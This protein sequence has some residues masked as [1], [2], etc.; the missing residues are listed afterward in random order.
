MGPPTGVIEQRI[1][2]PGPVGMP[3]HIGLEFPG[4]RDHAVQFL[5]HRGDGGFHLCEPGKFGPFVKF[6]LRHAGIIEERGLLVENLPATHQQVDRLAYGYRSVRA[7]EAGVFQLAEQKGL[8]PAMRSGE[9]LFRLLQLGPQILR[10]SSA[11]ADHVQGRPVEAVGR[12]VVA[13]PCLEFGHQQQRGEMAL[14]DRQQFL[15][16]LFLAAI[17]AQHPAGVGQQQPLR[18]GT[19]VRGTYLFQHRARLAGIADAQSADRV[20]AELFGFGSGQG[21]ARDI[22]ET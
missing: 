15:Q 5:L 13:G 20:S 7:G 17:I 16:R 19:A 11:H 9:K 4:P 18:I 2:W 1:V 8:E 14:V 3:L 21:H 22:S 12:P 10:D 6:P